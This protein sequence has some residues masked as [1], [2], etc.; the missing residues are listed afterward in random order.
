MS[1]EK[2]PATLVTE[3]IKILTELTQNT[4]TEYAKKS[5]ELLMEKQKLEKKLKKKEEKKLLKK[6]IKREKKKKMKKLL[7]E[8]DVTVDQN[9]LAKKLAKIWNKI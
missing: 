5:E 6:A 2:T 8:Y 4:V 9:K 7:E 1:K 3:T